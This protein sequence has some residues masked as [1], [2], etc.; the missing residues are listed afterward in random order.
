MSY[1][2]AVFDMDGTI[3]NTIDDLADSMNYTLESLGYNCEMDIEAVKSF[4]GS[5]VEVA[6]KRAL[7]YMQGVNVDDLE[8]VGTPND[9]LSDKLDKAEIE[10]IQSAFSPYYRTHCEIKTCAYD[11][12]IE[13]IKNL[14][15]Q[16]IKTAVVSNK[17]DPAVQILT[18]TY[19]EGLFDSA[20]GEQ[21]TVRRKPAP[22]S[23]LKVIADLN[24]E[25]HNTVYI[26]DSEIDIETSLN[27]GVDC[28]S[29]DWGFK[30]K[31]FLKEHNAQTIVSTSEELYNEIIK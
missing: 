15:R 10:K 7:L 23:V 4:F 18:K 11:G 17:P 19:F 31:E 16:G 30:T 6:V 20:V 2:L 14:R 25:K 28:I 21:P 12:I 22:D 26:G 29:V 9:E 3:L 1:T 24:E 8:V 13:C 5:G 27:V